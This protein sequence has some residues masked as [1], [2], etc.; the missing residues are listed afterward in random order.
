M[1]TFKL[2]YAKLSKEYYEPLQRRTQM[3]RMKER[4][5]RC[6]VQRDPY[7]MS[8]IHKMS[9]YAMPK[10]SAYMIRSAD[11][12]TF[13]SHHRSAEQIAATRKAALAFKR[14]NLKQK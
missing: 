7:K 4:L 2:T 8:S 10:Q 9:V 14:N 6:N 5:I 13:M 3:K 11:V 1:A 12:Q